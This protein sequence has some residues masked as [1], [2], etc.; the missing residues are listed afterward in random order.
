MALHPGL[1]H[2][3]HP[4]F[5]PW[6]QP[7]SRRPLETVRPAGPSRWRLARATNGCHLCRCRGTRQQHQWTVARYVSLLPTLCSPVNPALTRRFSGSSRRS[8]EAPSLRA[9]ARALRLRGVCPAPASPSCGSPPPRGPP[10]A[11]QVCYGRTRRRSSA[12]PQPRTRAAAPTDGDGR[13]PG[14]R[15]RGHLFGRVA[16]LG[17][18]PAARCVYSTCIVR[19][20]GP[21]CKHTVVQSLLGI[22]LGPWGARP[23]FD[24]RC[25]LPPAKEW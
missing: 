13:D 21:E 12:L 9:S 7:V 3:T 17:P 10:A 15:V 14:W 20:L 18:C 8:A 16:V 25:F 23:P 24:H 22:F 4:S 1:A 19:C 2:S 5:S 11:G 6:P